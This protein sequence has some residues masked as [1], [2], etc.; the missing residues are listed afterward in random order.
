MQHATNTYVEGSPQ[1]YTGREQGSL[2]LII[3]ISILY[4]ECIARYWRTLK[5]EKSDR[6]T[7]LFS[8][9]ELPQIREGVG[10]AA[11]ALCWIQT[12]RSSSNT[13]AVKEANL[14][15]KYTNSRLLSL[16]K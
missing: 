4:T 10:L 9:S 11:V 16:R 15:M 8:C 5:I 1:L 3:H 12:A 6:G 7:G 14:Q 13:A 2:F